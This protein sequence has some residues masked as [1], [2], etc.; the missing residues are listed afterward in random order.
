MKERDDDAGDHEENY[1][2]AQIGNRKLFV[3]RRSFCSGWPWVNSSSPRPVRSSDGLVL[4][5]EVVI[6]AILG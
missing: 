4:S 2:L 3:Q 1:D 6:P 5:E